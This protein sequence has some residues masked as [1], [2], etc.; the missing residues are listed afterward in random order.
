VL[1]IPVRTIGIFFALGIPLIL[2]WLY[3]GDNQD[4]NYSI[5]RMGRQLMILVVMIIIIL[6]NSNAYVLSV[7]MNKQEYVYQFLITRKYCTIRF[8]LTSILILTLT[9]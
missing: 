4:D 3:V 1:R 7:V 2:L 5:K 8:Y 9:V 6:T